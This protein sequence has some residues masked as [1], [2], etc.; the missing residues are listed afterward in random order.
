MAQ[1][2]SGVLVWTAV[3]GGVGQCPGR[4]QNVC[5]QR[6]GRAIAYLRVGACWAGNA[7]DVHL[8]GEKDRM[9]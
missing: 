2:K 3:A 4:A 8:R 7:I 9:P 5:V 1:C 6:W